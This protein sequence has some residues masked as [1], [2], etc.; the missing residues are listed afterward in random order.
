MRTWLL[1]L[2]T[3]TTFLPSA[4]TD[5]KKPQAKRGADEPHADPVL[6]GVP[7]EK[8]TC[9]SVVTED[10][11]AAALGGPVR[12][13]ESPFAP[14]R[15]VPRPCS[16]VFGSPPADAGAPSTEEAWTFDVD[17]R[18]SYQK[19]ADALFEQYTQ[20]SAELVDR[21]AREVGPGKTITT[22][23]GVALRAPEAAH[24]VPVGRRGLD[25]HG[26]G[27][28]FV[29]DDA[30]CYVRVVGPGAERRLAVAQLVAR[31]L[32]EANAP[33]TP[34]TTPVMPAAAP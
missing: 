16:Y 5:D 6:L 17:C 30:P 19:L 15:G 14:P 23:A 26:Q 33:M 25:H 29:D 27:I 4:C 11:L 22:D 1:A 24:E 31:N 20:T 34:H 7:A 8:W 13:V 3:A 32:R 12:A 10:E 2:A 9:A 21:Y 28:L 18:E